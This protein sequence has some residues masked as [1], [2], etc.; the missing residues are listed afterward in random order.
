MR[1]RYRNRCYS[2]YTIHTIHRHPVPVLKAQYCF[3]VI[4]NLD[5]DLGN[6]KQKA[7]RHPTGFIALLAMFTVTAVHA[8]SASEKSSLLAIYNALNGQSWATP[9]NVSASD[10]CASW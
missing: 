10:P 8:V 7:M 2:F 5:G 3:A 9:W 6:H 4:S 1:L